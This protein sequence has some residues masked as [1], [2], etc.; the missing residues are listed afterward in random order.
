MALRSTLV[1]LTLHPP[2]QKRSKNRQQG[3]ADKRQRK[4]P[5]QPPNGGTWLDVSIAGRK[6]ADFEEYYKEQGFVPEGEW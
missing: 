3:D 5:A 2:P 4:E 1:K 6:N